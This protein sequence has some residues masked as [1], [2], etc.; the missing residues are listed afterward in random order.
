MQGN[1]NREGGK[2]TVSPDPEVTRDSTGFPLQRYLGNHKSYGGL[3][4]TNTLHCDRRDHREHVHTDNMSFKPFFM[5]EI[6]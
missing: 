1:E 4:R 2:Q 5:A 3:V 6:G